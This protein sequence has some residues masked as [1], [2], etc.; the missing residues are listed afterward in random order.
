MKLCECGCGK[1]VNPGRRFIL[2]HNRRK[3]IEE[4]KPCECGCGQLAKPGNRFITGHNVKGRIRSPETRRLIGIAN[5]GKVVS[6]ESIQRMKETTARNRAN[7]LIASRK[8]ES[9]PSQVGHL[10]SE[11]T[12]RLISIASKGKKRGPRPENVRRAIG[13]ASRGRKYSEETR[14]KQS[15]A[16]RNR[17]PVTEATKV[18]I[19]AARARQVIPFKDT[20][21]EVKMQNALIDLG[22]VFTKHK[23]ILGQPD[24]FIDPNVCIFCDGDYWHNLP[25]MKV[26][27]IFVTEGLEKDGYIVLR[28]WEHEIND[29]LDI[30]LKKIL[31]V[32][33]LNCI[34]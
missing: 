14:R 6:K 26:R 9:R 5:A 19:R 32:L 20:S 8:G 7:G 16:A 25:N 4:V 29:E 2:G 27:G 13:N 12:R 28:F 30:C 17:P 31:K 10:V 33:V 21:I 15:I 22:I 1:E 11:E 34:F 23:R 24:L 3:P 18:L